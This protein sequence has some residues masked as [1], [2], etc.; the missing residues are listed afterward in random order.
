MGFAVDFWFLDNLLG[1]LR[2]T[3]AGEKN[4]FTRTNREQ[5]KDEY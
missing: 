5:I 3:D 2:I 1:Q 4:Q